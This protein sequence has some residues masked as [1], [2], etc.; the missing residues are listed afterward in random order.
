MH[1]LKISTRLA[2]FTAGLSFLLLVMG[3]LGLWGVHRSN[4]SLKT[5]YDDR[6]IPLIQLSEV[7]NLLMSSRLVLAE[8]PAGADF[9]AR[10]EKIQNQFTRIDEVWTAYKAT[11]LTAEEARLA[12]QFEH[13]FQIIKTE[14]L[15]NAVSALRSNRLD[16]V[17]KVLAVQPD[18]L[19]DSTDR[20]LQSLVELQKNVAKQEYDEA[21]DRYG[22]LWVVSVLSMVVG[23]VLAAAFGAALIR[24]VSR[25]LQQAIAISNAVA[26]GDLQQNIVIQGQDEVAQVL[27]ALANMQ[28]ALRRLVQEVRE[29]AEALAAASG[30]IAQGNADLAS[31]TERQASSLEETSTAMQQVSGAIAQNSESAY[32]ANQLAH[33]AS[34]IAV[35]GG[36]AVAHVVDTMSDINH[37]SQRISDIIGVI[38]G[39]AFQTNILA[40]NASVEAARAGEQGRGFAVVAS[41]V[42]NLAVRSADAAKEIKTLIT[43]NVARVGLG[44]QQVDEAGATMQQV[45]DSIQ[46]VTHIMGEIS[47]A[48][49]QQTAGVQNVGDAVM[50][51]DHGTQQNA[52]LVEEMSAAAHALRDQAHK[53][54]DAVGIFKV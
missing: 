22:V 49:A 15:S 4:A 44:T 42:R 14:M 23:V 5:V 28:T 52:A 30:Q 27:H 40:L 48:S 50:Q 53:L 32:Q 34:T 39:I 12:E 31:R 24:Q 51:M 19:Y 25:S 37:S 20:D 13:D 21:A 45:V 3:S 47:T 16:A 6:V 26:N 33:S 9:S 10:A 8:A 38:D 1:R 43:A 2:V 11:W 18:N 17:Q 41:E 54:V 7:H 36:Q 46:R 35:Q 29:N